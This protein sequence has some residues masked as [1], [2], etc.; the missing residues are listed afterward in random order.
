MSENDHNQDEQTARRSAKSIEW[1]QGADRMGESSLSVMGWLIDFSKIPFDKLSEGD[2]QNLSSE[3]YVFASG[4][5]GMDHPP[6]F[7][8][9]TPAFDMLRRPTKGEAQELQQLV[10][11]HLRNLHTRQTT[12]FRFDTLKL[13]V[14]AERTTSLGSQL[15]PKTNKF[16]EAFAYRLAQ[17]LGKHGVE[18]GECVECHTI[19]LATRARHRY[20]GARCRNRAG[21][22][23]FRKAR[24]AHT[25]SDTPKKEGK[26]RHGKKRK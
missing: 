23:E 2:F 11:S 19:F 1:H 12:E 13:V 20:C 25:A 21:I 3:L 4:Y 24:T 22:R 17:I 26:A 15:F 7:I 5:R 6:I 18:L 9:E 16:K 14:M 8:A 10:L